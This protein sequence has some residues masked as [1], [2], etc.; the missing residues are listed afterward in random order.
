MRV[1]VRQKIP[2][3]PVIKNAK[4]PAHQFPTPQSGP[5][6]NLLLII[7]INPT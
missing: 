7:H 3:L 4:L 5:Q 6:H 2:K 1:A